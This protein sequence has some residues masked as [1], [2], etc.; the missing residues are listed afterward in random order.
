VHE[1][2]GLTPINVIFACGNHRGFRFLAT[3]PFWMLPKSGTTFP[4]GLWVFWSINAILATLERGP[5]FGDMRVLFRAVPPA[6]KPANRTPIIVIFACGNPQCFVISND[7]CL[8]KN[9]SLVGFVRL[10]VP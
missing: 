8:K 4:F 1:R 6:N 7:F 9:G 3:I 10:L 2:G 5:I